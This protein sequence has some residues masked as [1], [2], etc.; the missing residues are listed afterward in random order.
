MLQVSKCKEIVKII[1]ETKWRT[2][3]QYK[4]STKQGVCTSER[5]IK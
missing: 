5:K 4:I 3:C 2:K 1:A